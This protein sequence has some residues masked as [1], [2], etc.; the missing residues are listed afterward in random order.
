MKKLKY[1]LIIPV[2]ILF[3]GVSNVLA[4][5]NNELNVYFFYGD[6]CPHCAKEEVFLE[7]IEKKYK[8]V[9]IHRYE[10]WHNKDNT[11]LLFDIANKLN[12]EVSGVPVLV[13][14]NE[15]I[16]GYFNDDTTGAKIEALINKFLEEGCTD[17]E[18]P[19]IV[20][21]EINE[22]C[23]GEC[24]IGKH[25]CSK[26]C[27]CQGGVVEE[28][29]NEMPESVN[30]P[31]FGE[32]K[33]KSVS[34]PVFTI[35]IAGA[36]GFNP[37]AMWILLFLISLLLGMENRVRMWILGTSFIVAS[38]LVYFL[39]LSAWLNFFIFLGFVYW[40]RIMI[41]VVALG[42]GG[43]HLYD[44]Y[45]NKDGGCAVTGGEKRRKIFDRLKAITHEKSF[46]M[47][48]TGIVL[49][50]VAVNL[51]EL[52]CS[53]GL[54]AVYTQVLALSNLPA[55]QYYLY[56]FLYIFIFMLDDMVVFLIAMTTL[57][58]KALSSKYTRYAGL[59]GGII[60]LIIGLLL[61]FKP[62]WLMFG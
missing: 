15:A 8:E 44:A 11:K 39:F 48:L 16:T 18:V 37:C 50:A 31:F 6:G 29:N 12:I 23:L 51:V 24:A 38:G 1:L 33:I 61:I 25:Q 20:N 32:V 60:M 9:N 55:W 26:N 40:I 2:L 14:G 41:G 54:P 46:W 62:G 35:L 28:K 49:L 5:H 21:N 36:D 43:Y 30:V 47:A 56:L 34:L 58:M 7:K 4:D 59:V 17:T 52:V 10:V 27:G 53:A 13:I 45:K 22:Q 42:S 3:F 19:I 57:Q